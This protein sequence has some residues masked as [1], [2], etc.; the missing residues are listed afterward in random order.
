KN[1]SGEYT[2]LTGNQTG[3]LLLHYLLSQKF[4]EGLLPKNGVVLKTIVT[5][6]FG[7]RVAEDYG[8]ETVDT[9][10]G[11]KY[12]GE[13]I[14]EYDQSNSHKFLFGYEESY[15]YLIGDFV[16]D[17]DAVQICL[18]AAEAAAYYKSQG[19]SLYDGLIELYEKYGWFR[20]ELES[21]TLKGKQGAEKISNV[22]DVFRER[23]PHN[24]A[25]QAV[26]SIEDYQ[27]R[28]RMNPKSEAPEPLDLPKSNVLKYFLEDG[29]W[30]CLRP[31]GTE[32]KIKLYFG[33]CKDTSQKSAE[34]LEQI[35]TAVMAQVNQILQE[36]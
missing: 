21:I 25:D 22:M 18:F 34:S 2:V 15:G 27:R 10:T 16:R 1:N 5:S 3:A 11:F 6:E 13:K 14:K 29:S 4:A 20:E 19:K 36:S 26:V 17:K 7:R 23:P 24:V 28:E 9:L 35:V 12:I 32:P 31:S 33:V 30:F 8:V